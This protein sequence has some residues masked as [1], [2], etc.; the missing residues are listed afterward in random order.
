LGRRRGGWHLAVI[1]AVARVIH[2]VARLP[3]RPGLAAVAGLAAVPRRAMNVAV[4]AARVNPAEAVAALVVD[5]PV[6]NL[7]A[8]TV[9]A[10]AALL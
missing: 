2:P 5:D 4:E 8:G 1:H 9:P 10:G 3:S 6:D 7:L